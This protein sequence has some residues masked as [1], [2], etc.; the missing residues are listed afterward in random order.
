MT[1]SSP[2]ISLK[3][4]IMLASFGILM[5]LIFVEIG[6]RLVWPQQTYGRVSGATADVF[7][8]SEWL[9]WELTPN[10]ARAQVVEEY[11]TVTYHVEINSLGFRDDEFTVEPASDVFRIMAVGDSFTYGWASISMKTILLFLK[12]VLTA[13]CTDRSI[14]RSSMP[15]TQAAFR[16]IAITYFCE[17]LH[18]HISPIWL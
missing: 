14:M 2:N 13:D 6:L 5:S 7:R 4:R 15:G 3:A 9:V 16:P 11:G 1:T 18:R 17:K 8:E 10:V 12:Y